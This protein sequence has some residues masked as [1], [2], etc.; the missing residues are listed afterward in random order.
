MWLWLV[1]LRA[2]WCSD[3]W[4]DCREDD[5]DV[6]YGNVC[7]RR[8]D[9]F[10]CTIVQNSYVWPL[11]GIHLVLTLYSCLAANDLCFWGTCLN[12]DMISS[13]HKQPWECTTSDKQ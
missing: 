2:G 4:P 5:G 1:V 8:Y 11:V 10:L 6:L 12:Y 13:T 7:V 9:G 3:G